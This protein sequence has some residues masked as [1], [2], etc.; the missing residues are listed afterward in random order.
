[1]M[2]LQIGIGNMF[3]K[4]KNLF[5]KKPLI[6]FNYGTKEHPTLSVGDSIYSTLQE[7]ALDYIAGFCGMDMRIK[8]GEYTKWKVIDVED[9]DHILC[10]NKR[11]DK[12][13]LNYLKWEDGNMVEIPASLSASRMR[14]RF[15]YREK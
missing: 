1:M 14:I 10:K 6:P 4:I 8:S 5:K 9:R 12:T 7:D 11:G 15:Y 13:F 2:I 3:E